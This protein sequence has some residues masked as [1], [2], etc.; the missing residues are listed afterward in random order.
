LFSFW[1]VSLTH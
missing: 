1:G